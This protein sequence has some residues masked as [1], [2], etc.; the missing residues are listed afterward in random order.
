MLTV[1]TLADLANHVG[2]ELGVSDWLLVDQPM[3]DQFAAVTG[4]RNWYHVDV[5]RAARELPGGRTLAHGMLTQSLSIGLASQILRV[6]HHGRALN[7]GTN[8]VR[9]PE[10][11]YVG[12]RVRLRMKML[13]AVPEKGGLMLT[14]QYVM[15][16]EGAQR[17]AMIAEM[18]TLVYDTP[19]D[20]A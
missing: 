7:Y 2:T 1:R 11:V 20:A 6:T 16:L 10:P 9:Y 14:R 15:E 18:Q 4:D 13:S 3:I 8:K 12:A 17:P 19:V 5:E